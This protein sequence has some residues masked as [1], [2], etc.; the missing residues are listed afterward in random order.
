LAAASRAY[1]EGFLAMLTD[2]ERSLNPRQRDVAIARVR[3]FA[4][5]F[6][7]LAAAR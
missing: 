3:E 5:D 4:R 2:L 7:L 1:V 6:D